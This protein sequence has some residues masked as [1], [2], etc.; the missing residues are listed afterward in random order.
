VGRRIALGE[1]AEPATE[2]CPRDPQRLAIAILVA[3]VADQLTVARTVDLLQ[4]VRVFHDHECT[5]ADI[6][7]SDRVD[8]AHLCDT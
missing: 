2:Q 5:D 4:L 6:Q 7:L 3:Q 8:S 1:R